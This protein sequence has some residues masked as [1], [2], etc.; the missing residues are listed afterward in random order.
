VELDE[1][2]AG[3]NCW[4]GVVLFLARTTYSCSQPVFV[5]TTIGPVTGLP[6]SLVSLVD[7]GSR[8][9]NA[10]AMDNILE[11]VDVLLIRVNSRGIHP[12]HEPA[13]IWLFGV[14]QKP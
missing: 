4:W 13:V 1:M 3:W 9:A 2:V 6:S 10:D 7:V 5:F 12:L 11:V 8:E 14:P